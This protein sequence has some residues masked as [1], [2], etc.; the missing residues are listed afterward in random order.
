[1]GPDVESLPHSLN[2]HSACINL[3]LKY[4]M[5]SPLLSNVYFLT[6]FHLFVIPQNSH[7]DKNN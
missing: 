1:M 7:R 6:Y 5:F 4:R 2:A 3:L